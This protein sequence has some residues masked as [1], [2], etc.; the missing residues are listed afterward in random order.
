M[1]SARET[2]SVRSGELEA[3]ADQLLREGVLWRHFTWMLPQGHLKI[4]LL[5]KG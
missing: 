4:T 5:A 2:Q 3:H 1:K